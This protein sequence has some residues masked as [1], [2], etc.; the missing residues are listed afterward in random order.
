MPPT[1][2]VRFA[3]EGARGQREALEYPLGHRRLKYGVRYRYSTI[4]LGQPASQPA[5]SI[6]VCPCTSGG[7]VGSAAR[8]PWVGGRISLRGPRARSRRD[9]GRTDGSFT[10]PKVVAA[11]RGRHAFPSVSLCRRAF[12][13]FWLW[14]PSS[15]AADRVRQP[16][17]AGPLHLLA[18]VSLIRDQRFVGNPSSCRRIVRRRG[19]SCL[20]QQVPRSASRRRW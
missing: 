14:K 7:R 2:S 19:G 10:E 13:L 12:A 8:D 4:L 5:A 18:G 3:N 15:I 16:S 1:R 9:G 11:C 17:L 6:P 20:G